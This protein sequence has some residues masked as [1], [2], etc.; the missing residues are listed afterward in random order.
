MPTRRSGILAITAA[1][2]ALLISS[3]PVSAEDTDSKED[4]KPLSIEEMRTH[5]TA[6]REELFLPSLKGIRG[7]AYGVAGSYPEGLELHKAIDN[8]LKQLPILVKRIEDLEPGVT[9][10]IDGVLQV[11]CLGAGG[12]FALVELTLSQWCSLER[13]PKISVRTITYTDQAVCSHSL[14]KETAD[15]L[16][17]QFIIDFQKV[18]NK[19]G[20]A[21]AES[22]KE[23]L[24]ADDE[25]VSKKKKKSKG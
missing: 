25:P 22:S 9:K 8:R 6:M 15:H 11:K 2:S 13:D 16:I 24:K 4:K 17:N 18:N 10:P 1:L 7:L 5:R 3:L 14:I 12:R 19:V 21:P 23:S 20:A